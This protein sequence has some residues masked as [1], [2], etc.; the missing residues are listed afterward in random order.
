MQN[1]LIPRPSTTALSL[2]SGFEALIFPPNVLLAEAPTVTCLCIG[3][4]LLAHVLAWR[5]R[6][7]FMPHPGIELTPRMLVWWL[8]GLFLAIVSDF[9]PVCPSPPRWCISPCRGLEGPPLGYIP[10]FP[11]S[12]LHSKMRATKNSDSAAQ[13]PPSADW[14][15]PHFILFPFWF[16]FCFLFVFCWAVA[17]PML[18]VYF[19]WCSV[20]MI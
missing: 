5:S 3:F 20:G 16:C 15:K 8:P 2:V 10:S 17:L 18:R 14:R 13:T 9:C 7:A 19:W 12:S 11:L 1:R 4:T 6:D